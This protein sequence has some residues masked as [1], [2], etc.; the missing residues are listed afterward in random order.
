MTLKVANFAPYL[1]GVLFHCENIDK[2]FVS[3]LRKQVEKVLRADT[4]SARN[5][6]DKSRQFQKV[7]P[8]NDVH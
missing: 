2:I 5:Q 4:G 8:E 7:E 3:T 1:S 6:N